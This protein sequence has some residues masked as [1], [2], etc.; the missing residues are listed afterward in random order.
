[1]EEIVRAIN[2]EIARLEQVKGLLSG[3]GNGRVDRR[4]G[5]M[6]A[7]TKAKISAALAKAW[8]ARRGKKK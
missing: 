6:N 5:P 3:E 7:A 1:V 8:A 2:L 4:R